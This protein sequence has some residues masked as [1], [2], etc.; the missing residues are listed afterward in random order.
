MIKEM[1]TKE[2]LAK[3]ILT[4]YREWFTIK[5]LENMYLLYADKFD[6]GTKELVL[7][8]RMDSESIATSN[9]KRIMLRAFGIDFVYEKE[10]F[11]VPF[12]DDPYKNL[13]EL[14]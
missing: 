14:Q 8:K 10:P 6:T 2:A 3:L 4:D 11:T 9:E 5:D 13:K 1:M 12:S 7:N